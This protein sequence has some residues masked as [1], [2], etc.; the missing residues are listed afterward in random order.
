[1]GENSRKPPL[2]AS[3]ERKPDHPGNASE[4]RPYPLPYALLT[5][6]RRYDEEEEQ[7]QPAVPVYSLRIDESLRNYLRVCRTSVRPYT[8]RNRDKATAY[9]NN[10]LYSNGEGNGF[11]SA[12]SGMLSFSDRPMRR[13]VDQ[14]YASDIVS[15]DNETLFE[16]F[17]N[18][19]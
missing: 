3:E 14:T 4:P 13:N 11:E 2:K 19:Q 18:V 15:T 10:L 6:S 12:V 7:K 16:A 9:P 1:M 5:L 8:T 17:I